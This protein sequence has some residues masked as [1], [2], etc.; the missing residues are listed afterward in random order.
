MPL[1]LQ[2]DENT[3]QN[4]FSHT[5]HFAVT[6]ITFSHCETRLRWCASND[7]DVLLGLSETS[8]QRG[9]QTGISGWRRAGERGVALRAAGGSQVTRRRLQRTPVG[10][11]K[12]EPQRMTSQEESLSLPPPSIYTVIQKRHTKIP[13]H[14]IRLRELSIS[15]KK[16]LLH[17]W[18][19]TS[20]PFSLSLSLSVTFLSSGGFASRQRPR[21]RV[22]VSGD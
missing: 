5:S 19:F 6:R 10:G 20:L 12:D 7:A 13:R 4:H 1:K 3:T 2:L 8:E 9:R 18:W 16:V 15:G 14:Y 17:D 22:T 11:G 21:G